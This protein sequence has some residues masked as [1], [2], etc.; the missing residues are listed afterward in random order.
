[1][2]NI[3]NLKQQNKSQLT[4][5]QGAL[6]A[7]ANNGVNQSKASN[8]D[9]AIT[10]TKEQQKHPLKHIKLGKFPP[11]NHTVTIKPTGQSTTD[12]SA[13]KKAKLLEQLLTSNYPTTFGSNSVDN[14]KLMRA[15]KND[16]D[17]YKKDAD[18]KYQF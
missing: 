13:W 14:S 3:N 5:L 18:N 4:N 17:D 8:L 2:V 7:M 16:V 11:M 10:V 9:G 6:I 12:V 15:W 1:M